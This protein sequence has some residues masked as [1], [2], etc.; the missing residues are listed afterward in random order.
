MKRLQVF[1]AL[2]AAVTVLFAIEPGQTELEM[3]GWFRY[4]NESESFGVTEPSAS[5]F[6]L[7]RGYVRMK[8]QW[9]PKF[10]SK[11]TI[12]IHSSDKYAEGATVRLKEAYLNYKPGGGDLNLTAG[13]QKHYFSSVYSWDYTN[14]FKSLA[15]AQGLCASADYGL[16][17]NGYLPAGFG[18]YQAGIY[19]GEGYKGAGKNVNLSPALVGNV[20]VAPLTGVKVGVSGRYNAVGKTSGSVTE[21]NVL[22]VAP[23]LKLAFGPVAVEGE[24]IIWNHTN[25]TTDT[26]GAVTSTDHV[27]SGLCVV[28]V[29][30][31]AKRRFEVHGRFDMWDHKQDGEG[32][33]GK[34]LLRY[35]AGVNWHPQR[36]E[37]GKPGVALQFAWLRTQL[38]SEGS[39]PVDELIAQFRFEWST[40]IPQFIGG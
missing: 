33:D 10:E 9:A 8:H 16:T 28:P 38:K 21:K 14:P 18:E 35:G 24:Y 40:V 32:D 22:G 13:L 15:D 6:S 11:L 36:R 20:R 25:E 31:L 12:D 3:N 23:M 2:A 37:K 29:V 19:N 4:T 34:S 26:L 27:Q 1:A 5:R 30:S 7:E 17:A 39:E